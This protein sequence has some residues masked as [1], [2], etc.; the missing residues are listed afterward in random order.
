MVIVPVRGGPVLAV[1][2]NV[3]APAPEPVAPAVIAIHGV[4]VVAVHAQPSAI[5]TAIGAPAPAAAGRAWL[6]GAIEAVHVTVPVPACVTVKMCP[7]MERVPVLA[8][9][10][11]AAT[12]KGTVPFPV[13]PAGP[14]NVIHVTVDAALHAQPAVTVTPTEPGPPAAATEMPPDAR[15]AEQALDPAWF[16]VKTTPAMRTVPE[17]ALPVFAATLKPVAPDPTPFGPLTTVIQGT[18]L[19]DVQAQP[20]P[21]ATSTVRT[22]PS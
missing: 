7:A 16:T 2:V 13:P 6:A 20:A 3:T 1:T 11:F 21:A 14:L 8:A 19:T 4:A 15:D 18:S 10:V 9:P 22:P 17:R 12:V 5:V